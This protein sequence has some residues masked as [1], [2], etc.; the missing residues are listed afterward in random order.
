MFIVSLVALILMFVYYGGAGCDLQKFFISFTLIITLAVTGLSITAWIAHGALLPSAVVTLYSYYLLFSALS[1]DPSSCN[2]TARQDT[3]HLVVGLLFGA[4]SICYAGWSL[5]NAGENSGNAQDKE[6]GLE[7][8]KVE[9]ADGEDEEAGDGEGDEKPKKKMV[10]V[11][12]GSTEVSAEDALA[13]SKRGAKFHFVMAAS[14]MYMAMLLTSWGSTQEV[15]SSDYG[16]PSPVA[17]DLNVESMWI[18][19]V[20]QWTTIGLYLWTL[21]APY[22]CTSREGFSNA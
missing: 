21:L 11:K 19:M 7:F 9:T 18:K 5:A 20:T 6:E 10:A 22:V 2:A 15:V 12:S 4:A 3:L 1:S 17:Y 14:A 16:I 8:Q 13:Q